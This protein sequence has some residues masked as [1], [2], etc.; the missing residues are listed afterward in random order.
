MFNVKNIFFLKVEK[1]RCDFSSLSGIVSW[2]C[3]YAQFIDVL[4]CFSAKM[5]FHF[6]FQIMSSIGVTQVSNSTS[7]REFRCQQVCTELDITWY[8]AYKAFQ[9]LYV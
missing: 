7:Y 5:S 8:L 9:L 6:I 4:V 1:M 2:N 3:R